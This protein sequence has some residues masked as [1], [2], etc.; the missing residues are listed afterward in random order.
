MDNADNLAR[1][2]VSSAFWLGF[3]LAI[4]DESAFQ[5]DRRI[6]R[7]RSNLCLIIDLA[8]KSRAPTSMAQAKL[9]VDILGNHYPERLGS[10]SPGLEN[11]L[12]S[13]LIGIGLGTGGDFE[14]ALDGE[15]FP[16]SG[17]QV[18]RPCD[19]SQGESRSLPHETDYADVLI[20]FGSMPL[21]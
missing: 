2:P 15:T 19:E 10:V 14:P 12:N 13:E 4:C 11:S 17:L 18:C 5:L 16:G 3:T 8:G 20:R 1:R 9:F 6:G 21:L 7:P